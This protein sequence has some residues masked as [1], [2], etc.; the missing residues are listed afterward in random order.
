MSNKATV[1]ALSILFALSLSAAAQQQTIT[2]NVV[3]VSDGDTL[4]GLQLSFELS[5]AKLE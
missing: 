4:N 2:G 3:G 5:S 1:R